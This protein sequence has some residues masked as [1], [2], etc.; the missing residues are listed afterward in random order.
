MFNL[1]YS[2]HLLQ[3]WGWVKYRFREEDKPK[4]EDAKQAAIKYL[5]AC[6]AEIIRRFINRTWRW[7]DAYRHGLTGAAAVW[8]V[9]RQSAHRQASKRAAAALDASAVSAG[10]R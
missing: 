1:I 9:R 5:D 7:M 3:Y 10:S 6:T 8:A 4:F 2:R